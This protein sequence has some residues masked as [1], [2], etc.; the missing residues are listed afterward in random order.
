M[1]FTDVFSFFFMSRRVV[2]CVM[3]C[4]GFVVHSVE[5]LLFVWLCLLIVFLVRFFCERVIFM[6]LVV[7]SVSLLCS[8]ACLLFWYSY[9]TLL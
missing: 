6:C 5:F 8:C 2:F 7:F 1:Y 4:A 9:M 3:C